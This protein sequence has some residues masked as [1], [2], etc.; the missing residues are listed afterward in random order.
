M[1]ETNLPL[2][3][4]ACWP[5]ISQWKENKDKIAGLSLRIIVVNENEKIWR[6][7]DLKQTS[8]LQE[9]AF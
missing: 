9:P 5:L 6:V 7:E 3:S 4:Y 2:F 1:G 8:T